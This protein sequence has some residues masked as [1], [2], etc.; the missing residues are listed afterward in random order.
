[1]N[2]HNLDRL[3]AELLH[4]YDHAQLVAQP[5][6]R[7]PFTNADGYAVGA[8]L[9]A[10]RRARGERTIG[11]KIGFTN[12]TL[13]EAYGV[14]RPMWAHVYAGTV[15]DAPGQAAEISLARAIA[16][17]IEPEVVFGLREA[18]PADV[19]DPAALL[20]HIAWLA[21]GFEIVDCHYAGWRFSS[22]DCTADFG[23]HA[24]LVVG[25]R[26]P[27]EGIAQLAEQL[28]HFTIVLRRDGEALASGGGANVLGSPLHALGFLVETLTALGAEPLAAGEIVT[29]GTLTPALD[30]APG[31][32]W[33]SVFS[34]LPLPGLTLR[35]TYS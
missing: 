31:Q 27:V 3:A 10:L 15:L 28:A 20:D 13:W 16:P 7:G 33:Q 23:L 11:R 4:A 25:Q 17:R 32:T 22:A 24:R 1:M 12:T 8:R 29:T 26:L 2:P 9:T 30:I 14:D 34:G 5:S 35:L 18:I 21:P 19:T 6:Q